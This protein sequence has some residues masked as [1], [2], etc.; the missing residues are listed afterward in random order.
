MVKGISYN[1]E[2][3]QKFH[4]LTAVAPAGTV[5]RD[6]GEHIAWSWRCDCGNY[7][8]LSVVEVKNGRKRTCGTCDYAK[9]G[10]LKA[11]AAVR[12]SGTSH[13][14]LYPRYYAWRRWAKK[15]NLTMEW[16][17]YEAFYA[18]FSSSYPQVDVMDKGQSR[19]WALHRVDN[20]L[21]YV[22]GN[23]HLIDLS[24]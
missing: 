19:R 7:A 4:F 18:W 5:W 13:S 14:W 1:I 20:R 11:I 3:G 15:K 21:G 8:V 6:N 24:Q 23:I 16:D 9:R 22:R 10:I 12:K 17:N 2:P